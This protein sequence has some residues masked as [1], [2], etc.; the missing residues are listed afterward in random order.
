M[1]TLTKYS[2]HLDLINPNRVA[3]REAEAQRREADRDQLWADFYYW[4]AFNPFW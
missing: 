2:D 1:L 3:M 4:I